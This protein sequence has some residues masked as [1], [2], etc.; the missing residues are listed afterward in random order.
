MSNNDSE[1][2][3]NV[4]KYEIQYTPLPLHVITIQMKPLSETK[5]LI[6]K[7]R[8]GD[9]NMTDTH[10]FFNSLKV[11]WVARIPSSD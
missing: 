3:N 6:R 10:S 8:A 5:T 9:L 2:R 7:I 4:L 1:T 11:K